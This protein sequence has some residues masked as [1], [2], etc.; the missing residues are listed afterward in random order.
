[1]SYIFTDQLNF[2]SGLLGD[3][4]TDTSSQ[5]PLAQRKTEINH[6]EKQF[7]K[8]TMML[9]ENSSSTI[10][11]MELAVPSGW[12]A[13]FAFYVT[14][15]NIKYRID[16]NREI[17]PSDLERWADYGGS[18]PYYF[19]WGFAGT[20]KIKFL[21]NA[22]AIN[23]TTY[24]WYYFEMPTT[25]L[26]D[27]ADVSIIPEEYRQASVH[28]AASNLLQQVGQYTRAQQQLQLYN[29][30]VTQGRSQAGRTYLDY[31]QPR[32]DFNII[33]SEV[34]DRQGQGWPN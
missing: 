15:S 24:D 8:D 28:K 32:P 1:M 25:D 5:W 20:R 27:G 19:F 23:G 14:V 33:D 29:N 4:N 11:N 31:D 21:G 16:N 18:I 12:F 17:A 7:A 22:S 34:P 13:T 30:L 9:Q 6:A 3:S 26:D 10:A 2:L